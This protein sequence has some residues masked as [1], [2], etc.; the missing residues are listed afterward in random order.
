[1]KHNLDL[2]SFLNYCILNDTVSKRGSVLPL[3]NIDIVDAVYEYASKFDIDE[4]N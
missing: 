2:T 1:M 4:K 3:Q